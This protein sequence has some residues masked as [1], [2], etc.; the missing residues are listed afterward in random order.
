LL[1][2]EIP[3]GRKEPVTEIWQ[4]IVNYTVAYRSGAR[5]RPRNKQRDNSCCLAAASAPMD[6]LSSDHVGTPADT[7]A[8]IEDLRFLLVRAD[9]L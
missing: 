8:T 2:R 5:Q 1:V 6:W 4:L 9:G 7:H 3:S